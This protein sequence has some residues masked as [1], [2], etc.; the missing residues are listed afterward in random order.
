[1][2]AAVNVFR[3]LPLVRLLLLCAVAIGVGVSATA[4]AFAL[5]GGPTP[6]PKPLATAVEDALTGSGGKSL[7]GVSA[8]ITLTNHLLEGVGLASGEGRGGEWTSSPLFTGASG[9]LWIAKDG[10]VRVEL[11]SQQGDTQ[12]LYDGHTL[13]LYD[14]ATNTLYRYTPPAGEQD[15]A[16]AVAQPHEAPTLA[17]VEQA[18]TPLSEHAQV[19]G[20]T[21]TDIAGQPAYSVRVSPKQTGSL[22]AGAELSFDASNG[23]PLRSAIYSTTSSSPVIE[24]AVNEISF[25]PVS[26]SVFAFTPPPG[27]TIKQL[28]LPR[29]GSREASRSS[30]DRGHKPIITIHGHGISAIT[31][32]EGRTKAG[33][34]TSAGAT[35]EGLPKVSINGVSASELRTEL[36]TVLSF[37]RSGV[38]YLLFGALSPAAIEEVAR[39]L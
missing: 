9:R 20:A 36:G 22:L 3:R 8:S 31:V 11:Q 7:E 27:V 30:A 13:Q 15:N 19:S 10:D 12:I 39:G 24:L 1:V 6:P 4:L 25:G 5:G 28:R 38:R 14:A 18:I 32:L 17:E 37:E 33:E 23:V 29:K 16:P 26:G 34:H 21:P 2:D 35:L